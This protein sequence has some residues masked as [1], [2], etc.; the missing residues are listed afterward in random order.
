[1]AAIVQTLLIAFLD[2]LLSVQVSYNSLSMGKVKK[3]L[4]RLAI[5]S[6][7]YFDTSA[8]EF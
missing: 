4:V 5:E 7:N 1:M 3:C 6:H 8:H 2:V